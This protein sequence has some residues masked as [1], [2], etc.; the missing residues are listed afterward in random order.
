MRWPGL[1]CH[2]GHRLSIP[3]RQGYS[4]RD[5]LERVVHVDAACLLR[6]LD[7]QVPDQRD[8]DDPEGDDLGPQVAR[9]VLE[10]PVAQ[11]AEL[12]REQERQRPSGCR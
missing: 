12:R 4:G 8:H 5:L 1:Q 9:E 10:V 2:P 3:S 11:N 6:V 7:E